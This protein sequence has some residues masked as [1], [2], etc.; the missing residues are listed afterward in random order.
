MSHGLAQPESCGQKNHSPPPTSLCCRAGLSDGWKAWRSER[1][2]DP[3]GTA[4]P[5]GVVMSKGPRRGYGDQRPMW[6]RT[7]RDQP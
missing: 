7:S 5:Q 3:T 2:G 6:G 4:M 1:K